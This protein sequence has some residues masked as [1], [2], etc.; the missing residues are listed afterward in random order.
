MVC[1]LPAVVYKLPAENHVSVFL[2]GIVFLRMKE[3]EE[4]LE[5]TQCGNSRAGLTSFVAY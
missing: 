1:K 2:S 4:G 5:L 3:K